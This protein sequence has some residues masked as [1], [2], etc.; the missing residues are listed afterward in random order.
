MFRRHTAT[1]ADEPAQGKVDAPGRPAAGRGSAAK[2]ESPPRP[3]TAPKGRPTPKRSQAAPRRQPIAAPGTRKEAVRHTRERQRAERARRAEGLR[4]G[5][6][7]YLPLRDQGPVR[8]F[9][10]D[11]VDSRRMLSE[12]YLYIFGGLAVLWFVPI[13]AVRAFIL[14]LM[15]A[16]MVTVVFEGYVTGRR[17]RK[18]AAQRFPGESTRGI[19]FYAGMRAAQIRKFRLPPARVKRGAKI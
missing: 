16:V 18:I 3:G 13:L 6:E 1:S 15:F 10:R 7:R 9:A 14:P 2:G 19:A 4:R 8:A 11:Y 12:Y 17:V 5:D